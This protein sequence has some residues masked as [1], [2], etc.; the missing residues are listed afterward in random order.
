MV[1]GIL[2][3][4]GCVNGTGGKREILIL[5][6]SSTLV[7]SSHGCSHDPVLLNLVQDKLTLMRV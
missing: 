6:L 4:T 2:I 5:I 7:D 3:E 1:I